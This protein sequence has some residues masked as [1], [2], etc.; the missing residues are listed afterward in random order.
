M[1]GFSADGYLHL[2]SMQESVAWF[3]ARGALRQGP[4]LAEFVDY[5]YLDYAQERLGRRGPAQSV[6]R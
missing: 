5:R 6:P 2:D 4:K 1:P 3:V